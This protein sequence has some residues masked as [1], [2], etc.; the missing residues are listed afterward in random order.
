M[1][2]NNPMLHN[3]TK[4]HHTTKR[5]T[6]VSAMAELA[7]ISRNGGFGVSTT[8]WSHRVTKCVRSTH[9]TGPGR[10]FFP[11]TKVDSF[12]VF[13][14]IWVTVPICFS[15]F[16]FSQFPNSVILPSLHLFKSLFCS[17]FALFRL[18][19][20]VRAVDSGVRQWSSNPAV[21]Y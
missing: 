11:R 10:Y 2:D 14:Q 9:S 15:I 21:T 3:N 6:V 4:Y 5:Q 16:Y 19:E 1:N 13:L 8:V 12:E 18:A 20:G 17:E 7:Q